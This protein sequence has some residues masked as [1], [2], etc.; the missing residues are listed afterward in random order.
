MRELSIVPSE[1]RAEEIE[2]I[3]KNFSED[4]Y[5]VIDFGFPEE[6]LSEASLMFTK[7]FLASKDCHNGFRAHN[8]WR[9]DKLRD[10][11]RFLRGDRRIPIPRKAH[12]AAKGIA[13]FPAVLRL[14]KEI[15]G[16]NPLL[17]Q[18]LSF[19]VGTEQSAHSDTVHF[20][21]WPNDG[22]M[23]GVWVALEDVDEENGPLV[24]YPGSHRLPELTPLSFGLPPG[25]KHYAAYEAK[26]ASY[27]RTLGLKPAFG[28]IKK[29]QAILWAG[30]LLHGGSKVR[31]RS[32]TRFSQVSHYFFEGSEFYWAP[33]SSDLISGRINKL[34]VD[35]ASC[36][37]VSP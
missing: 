31:D 30:N 32:R 6:L 7:E 18:T 33:L 5:A 15:Y 4:G 35:R 14:L 29:G 19:P 24:Y 11:V 1:L 34:A 16:F 13:L 28:L 23:C 12:D 22:R 26:L 36:L 20:N 3:K 25:R 2:S 17:F 9:R 10:L 21:C 8:A 27:I 37:G